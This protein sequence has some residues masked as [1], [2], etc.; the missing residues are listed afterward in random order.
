VRWVLVLMLI[1]NRGWRGEHGWRE[2]E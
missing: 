1:L 2:M